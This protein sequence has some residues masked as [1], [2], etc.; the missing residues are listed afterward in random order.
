MG[1]FNC[2]CNS[3][4]KK[5]PTAEK[6]GE[7]CGA[8]SSH[9]PVTSDAGDCAGFFFTVKSRIFELVEA[10]MAV[11]ASRADLSWNSMF[12]CPEQIHTSPNSTFLYVIDVG[13]EI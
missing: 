1:M 2:F 13:P 11:C 7:D 6:L 8:D 3:S 9:L 10:S 12:D 4:P 5:Y